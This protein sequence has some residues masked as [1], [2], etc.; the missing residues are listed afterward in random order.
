MAAPIAGLGVRGLAVLGIFIVAFDTS[1]D[2][3]CWYRLISSE[4]AKCLVSLL[5]FQVLHAPLHGL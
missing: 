5:F 3:G 2:G 4:T 1:S